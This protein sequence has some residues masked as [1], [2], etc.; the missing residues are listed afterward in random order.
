MAPTWVISFA[1]FFFERR[2]RF[3]TASMAARSR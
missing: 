3:G 1:V 2:L